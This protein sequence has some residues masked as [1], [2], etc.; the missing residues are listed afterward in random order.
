[1]AEKE[2]CDD[3]IV[4]ELRKRI[5]DKIEKD[6]R[7]IE[8]LLAQVEKGGMNCF[9]W[10]HGMLFNFF[11]GILEAEEKRDELNEELDKERKLRAE[12]TTG[13]PQVQT[14]PIEPQKEPSKTEQPDI[15]EKRLEFENEKL[16]NELGIK[17]RIL[18][19]KLE[20]E[21]AKFTSEYERQISSLKAERQTLENGSAKL[22]EEFARRSKLSAH[23]FETFLDTLPRKYSATGYV[24][25]RSIVDEWD[26]DLQSIQTKERKYT[27]PMEPELPQKEN[28]NIGRIPLWIAIALLF[29]ALGVAIYLG[30][31][32]RPVQTVQTVESYSPSDLSRLAGLRLETIEDLNH[33]Y[34]T[35]KPHATIDEIRFLHARLQALQNANNGEALK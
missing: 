12:T 35:L 9:L 27:L 32:P 7:K 10:L 16:R 3:E 5:D 1:M 23:A 19:L 30:T 33:A 15:E 17:D 24:M 21:R 29:L 6:E 25:L 28:P 8:A 34:D 2:L 26:G 18:E 20:A 13:P 11:N 4:E 31:R 22:A 14:A